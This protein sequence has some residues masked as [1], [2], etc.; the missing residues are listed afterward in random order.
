M[1]TPIERIRAGIDEIDGITRA[2]RLL[3]LGTR[4]KTPVEFQTL[5]SSVLKDTG[6]L[7]R[8]DKALSEKR[9]ARKT[10][11][12]KKWD[13]KGWIE[14]KGGRID[15]MGASNRKR[16]ADDDILEMEK[17][18]LAGV[19][20]EREE[21]T[22]RLM[23][24]RS[25][26]TVGYIIFADPVSLLTRKTAANAAKVLEHFQMLAGAGP[27]HLEAYSVMAAQTESG[28]EREAMAMAIN[29]RIDQL[30]RK[31]SQSLKFS[32][33]DNAMACCD[34]PPR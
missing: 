19:P 11:I 15:Q 2:D 25:H 16:F 32:R 14:T 26:L 8:M 17:E 18:I 9:E 21:I 33:A 27:K 5:L 20:R 10:N 1:P 6:A 7:S 13:R 12:R 28:P 31:S 34:T 22:A 23:D 29:M 24:A 4:H 3:K 30:D